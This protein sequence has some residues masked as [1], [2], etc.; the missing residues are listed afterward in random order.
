[1]SSIYYNISQFDKLEKKL[2]QVNETS[3]DN[4]LEQQ[5]EYQVGVK[6]FKIPAS[7]IDT[8]R[9]YPNRYI[10]G[11]K[12]WDKGLQSGDRGNVYYTVDLFNSDGYSRSE[13]DPLYEGGSYYMSV[14]SQF[15]FTQ[16]LTRSMLNAIQLQYLTNGNEISYPPNAAE[17]NT[18]AFV[19]ME[20]LCNNQAYNIGNY[21]S[22]ID[23]PLSAQS[24]LSPP[25]S[26][27]TGSARKLLGFT[28]H[29]Q[30][31][32]LVSGQ[33]VFM[34]DLDFNLSVNSLKDISSN[35]ATVYDLVIGSGL[36]KGVK[37]SNF[38]TQ[39]PNGFQIS[40]FATM[41]QGGQSEFLSSQTPSFFPKNE[42]DFQ[43]LGQP[44]DYMSYSIQI[45]TNSSYGVQ[46]QIRLTC[47]FK[48]IGTNGDWFVRSSGKLG[49][50][51][52]DSVFQPPPYFS[53]NNELEK[54]LQLNT[55]LGQISAPFDI[56]M[57]NAL[58]NLV[59]FDTVALPTTTLFD[60]YSGDANNGGGVL[61]YDPSV[62]DIDIDN[63]AIEIL[64]PELSL[65]KRNFLYS[66]IITA[67]SLS[68]DGE[69]EGNGQSQRKILSDFEIDPSTNFRDYLIYQ[70]QGRSVRYYDMNSSQP[71]REI[72][73]SVF[74]RDINNI[75]RPLEI[76]AGYTGSIKLH[77][78]KRNTIQY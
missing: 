46:P 66:I 74:Y 24:F 25:I 62:K 51:D 68:I 53:L 40:T 3:F 56:Y 42:V 70:P 13:F 49:T 9:I 34:D 28:L 20:L 73:V 35:S 50:G 76:G 19:N 38:N 5:N 72:F 48:T 63:S 18:T 27:N 54:R 75:I 43:I 30:N 23:V 32:T 64:E 2:F 12:F 11:V 14:N 37:L 78:Q 29:I 69:Y 7:E 59:G 4:I 22:I 77:F 8:F 36:L 44:S 33:D 39:F 65:F 47:S 45:Y 57:N 10:L 26:G 31:I 61:V 71:L 16:I 60:G 1:M 55:Y 58:Q 67:N 15:H 41:V 6:R 52:N 17:Q 21:S